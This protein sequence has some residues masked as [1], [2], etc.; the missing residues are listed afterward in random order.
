MIVTP[1][2]VNQESLSNLIHCPA[3]NKDDLKLSQPYQSDIYKR[4]IKKGNGEKVLNLTSYP[5]FF[6]VQ[7][8]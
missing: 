7:K 6:S 1:R 8:S 3:R 2:S 5:L 4:F